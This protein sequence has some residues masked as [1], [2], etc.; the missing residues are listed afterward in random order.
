[1][2]YIPKICGTCNGANRAL[3]LAYDNA[4]V[5]DNKKLYIY[6]EILHNPRVIEEL[7]VNNTK[8]IT[9]QKAKF[10]KVVSYQKIFSLIGII[11]AAIVTIN[12]IFCCCFPTHPAA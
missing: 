2:I 5:G 8:T 4:N 6:K 10:V 3:K 9:N 12:L 11:C 7:K 1:M